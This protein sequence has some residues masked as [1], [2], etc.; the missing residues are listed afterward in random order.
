MSETVFVV[1]SK[2]G[3]Y[4]EHDQWVSG[5]YLTREEA[6]R[7]VDEGLA[8]N[9]EYEVWN[10]RKTRMTYELLAPY[11]PSQVRKT[12]WEEARKIA[13][14][15]A[16]PEPSFEPTERAEILEFEIGQWRNRYG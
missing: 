2:S 13:T 9:R 10:D 5:V 12:E 3:E 14:E 11:R 8:R 15:N 6:Q 7:A 1:L 4:T 16:G